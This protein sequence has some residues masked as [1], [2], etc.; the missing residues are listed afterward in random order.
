[1][2]SS[3]GPNQ[4][5]W[6]QIYQNIDQDAAQLSKWQNLHQEGGI[7]S[8]NEQDLFVETNVNAFAYETRKVS[9]IDSDLKLPEDAAELSRL[10]GL[11]KNFIKNTNAHIKTALANANE[12][13]IDNLEAL[14]DRILQLSERFTDLQGKNGLITHL[15]LTKSNIDNAE[16]QEAIDEL[17]RAVAERVGKIERSVN[18]LSKVIEDKKEQQFIDQY[19]GRQDLLQSGNVARSKR[20]SVLKKEAITTAKSLSTEDV[21][22][23]ESNIA[24][25]IT[26]ETNFKNGIKFLAESFDHII[27]EYKKL[28]PREIELFKDAAANLNVAVKSSEE[29]FKALENLPKPPSPKDIKKCFKQ[30]SYYFSLFA[31]DLIQIYNQL[32]NLNSSLVILEGKGRGSFDK[33][34]EV[35]GTKLRRGAPLTSPAGQLSTGGLNQLLITLI[36]RLPRIQMYAENIQKLTGAELAISVTRHTEAMNKNTKTYEKSAKGIEQFQ[37]FME[38]STIE[39]EFS[40]KNIQDLQKLTSI[41]LKTIEKLIK[42]NN[43]R[44]QGLDATLQQILPIAVGHS[45]ARSIS[46]THKKEQINELKPEKAMGI[47]LKFL[48]LKGAGGYWFK[49]VRGSHILQDSETDAIINLLRQSKKLDLNKVQTYFEQPEINKHYNAAH[50]QELTIDLMVELLDRLVNF[51]T[52]QQEEGKSKEALKD[53]IDEIKDLNERIKIN[54]PLMKRKSSWGTHTQYSRLAAVAEK[55]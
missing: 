41:D 55:L 3:V 30:N 31:Y 37:T 7:L 54:I 40:E 16:K 17:L 46:H 25:L 36:Q 29:F 52:E 32:T 8:S 51:V 24:E 4:F 43:R 11:I 18:K 45:A 39:G 53:V 19:G 35:V 12:S 47:I 6:E 28:S 42:R 23:L 48:E 20:Q 15:T 13:S 5:N 50:A 49:S 44:D 9:H 2:T 10:V 33:S 14:Q 38:H 1:M 27:N 21:K 26:T 22:K 34:C